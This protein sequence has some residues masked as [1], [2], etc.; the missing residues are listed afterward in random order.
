MNRIL[1]SMIDEDSGGVRHNVPNMR[2]EK[3]EINALGFR[4]LVV[5]YVATGLVLTAGIA[6][7]WRAELLPRDAQANAR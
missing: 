3:W 1:L 7:A 5:L 6:L 2:Y 4:A